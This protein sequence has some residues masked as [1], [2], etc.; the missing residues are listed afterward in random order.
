MQ[1]QAGTEQKETKWGSRRLL[2]AAAVLLSR[3][4]DC[5]GRRS[6][7]FFFLS[8]LCFFSSFFFGLQTILPLLLFFFFLFF[9][10]SPFSPRLLFSSVLFSRFFFFPV[11]LFSFSSS[12]IFFLSL[13]LSLSFSFFFLPLSFLC[14]S[15][16]P[17]IYMGEKETYTPA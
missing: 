7:S 11:S 14:V 9:L 13:S 1:M 12:S 16:L 4:R 10:C 17:C 5:G 8:L 15:F 2:G 6:C 3:W